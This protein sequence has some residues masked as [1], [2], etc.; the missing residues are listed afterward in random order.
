MRGRA[1]KYVSAVLGA[2]AI[3][4]LAP[5]ASAV[6]GPGDASGVQ[7]DW[8]TPGLGAV[9]RLEPC[10]QAQQLLCG[11]LTWAWNPSKLHHGGLGSLMLRGFAWDGAAWRG[12][13]VTDPQDG[14]TYSG[15]IRLQGDVLILHGCA[16]PFCRDQTWRRLS[17][18][19][20]PP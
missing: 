3:A 12:G 17:S 16:G 8:A 5:T 1:R 13:V 6:P 14:R 7:D 10:A 11:R 2:V 15:E 4:V 9:V 19:P 20:R 18:I